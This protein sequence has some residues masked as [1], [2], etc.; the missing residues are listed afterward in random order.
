MRTSCCLMQIP[1]RALK[2]WIGSTRWCATGRFTLATVSIR[3]CAKS[4]SRFQLHAEC[5]PRGT[6]RGAARPPAATKLS[7]SHNNPADE[8][9]PAGLFHPSEWT[10]NSV[11]S[12]TGGRVTARGQR[13]GSG[14]S[15]C[16]PERSCHQP[17]AIRNPVAGRSDDIGG[18]R[19]Y[20]RD[21]SLRV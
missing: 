10:K 2:I 11:L 3:S 20:R 8:Y 9:L 6:L 14:S 16:S 4:H 1:W 18:N 7:R 5:P 12:L 13:C 15:S 17:Y 19:L 21:H